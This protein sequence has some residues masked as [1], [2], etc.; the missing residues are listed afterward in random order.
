MARLGHLV[1]GRTAFFLCD[2]QEKFVNHISAVDSVIHVANYLG[3][4]SEVCGGACAC[5][6]LAPSHSE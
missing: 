4:C 2:V 1:K 6:T 3:R 5:G